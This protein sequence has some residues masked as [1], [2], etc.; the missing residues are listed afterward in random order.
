[1]FSVMWSEHCSYKSSKPLLRTLPT[2]GE[3]VVAGPGE[4]AGVISIGDGLAVAFKIES[5]NH[6]SAV[7]PYQGAATGVG[8]ILRDIFT[9][10]A[11]PIA[12]LDALRFGDPADA[13]DAAPRRRRRPR[14]RRLRQ[15]RRRAD[16]RRRARLRPDATRA[17]RS[18][19]SW[20][21]GCMEERLLTLAAAPGPGQPGRAV[22]V[23]DRPRRD[24]RR[25]GPR[26]RD[27]HRRRPVQAAV[28]PGRRPVRREAAHRGE[29][30]AHRARARGGPPGPR[31]RRDHVR[32]LG[33]RGPRRDRDAR[34]PRRDPAARAGPRAVRGDDLGVAGADVRGGPARPL[35]G[36]PRGLHALG[37]AGRDHRP[38]HRRR[39]HRDRRGR[40]RRRRAPE[41]RRP[42]AR[43]D[44][45]RAL[46]SDAIVHAAR[47]DAA[48]PPARPPRRPGAP[49]RAGRP[50]AGARHGPR[51]RPAGP[52][53][54][55]RTSP[56]ATRSSTSTTRRSARTR[57]PDRAAAPRSC[58]SRARPR[59]SSPR[60]TA[61]RASAPSTRGSGAA[62]SVAEATRNVSITGA[63]PLGVTNCLNYGDP[64]RPE[65]FWQLTEGVRGLGDA[66]RALGLPVTGGNVSLY[67]ES[68]AGAIA[69]DAGDRR[70]RAARR[71]R[72]AR[73]P[74]LRAGARHDPARRRGRPGPG[75]LRLR[76]AR[77]RARRGRP[78]GAGPGPRGGAPGVHPRGDRPRAR[79]LGA[80][81]VRRRAGGRARRER[82]LGR[83]RGVGPDR[84]SR[85]RRRSTCSARARR[86]SS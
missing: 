42:R 30:R 32:D 69:P 5:H 23:D 28:R 6:P 17:T 36:R 46:T 71:R 45:G 37:P 13:A 31:R 40:A 10:G 4:N 20:P 56:R 22:R 68:P 12:V 11:R 76:G 25:V 51:R 2:A 73:R 27:L 62:L 70:R 39:R 41:P 48:D 52:A 8:G 77:R 24:R 33:D 65:A 14:R 81:R 35:G 34:R 47:R 86:G 54:V 57:S 26:E 55:G 18:S 1:M 64:T 53:R 60:R 7:E 66:C 59:R 61:T 21:S 9:M 84:R 50:P 67:N 49:D 29:P 80:G 38:G 43:A 16:G 85:T 82:D 63:R 74:G 44:P 15:L 3:G 78:A 58:A 75:R 83:P 79:R 72:H 19:T